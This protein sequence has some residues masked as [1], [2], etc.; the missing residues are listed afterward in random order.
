[1]HET[2]SAQCNMELACTDSEWEQILDIAASP[3]PIQELLTPLFPDM[4]MERI[5]LIDNVLLGWRLDDANV[6]RTWRNNANECRRHVQLLHTWGDVSPMIELTIRLIALCSETSMMPWIKRT[7][8]C[9]KYYAC[10]NSAGSLFAQIIGRISNI[11][12]ALY[13]SSQ[14]ATLRKNAVRQQQLGNGFGH[15]EAPPLKLSHQ[16]KQDAIGFDISIQE[17]F[18]TDVE[19]GKKVG[20][21]E[22]AA[23][24]QCLINLLKTTEIWLNEVSAN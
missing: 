8:N 23:Q 20:Y 9:G 7:R 15:F 14:F 17:T 12:W 10:R 3:R 4:C 11:V 2:I 6:Y 21:C 5:K 16:M 1:M 13:I 24:M 19:F 22:S 18:A